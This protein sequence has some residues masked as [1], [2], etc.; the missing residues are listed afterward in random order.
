MCADVVSKPYANNDI[1]LTLFCRG[2]RTYGRFDKGEIAVGLPIA[3]FDSLA[4]GIVKTINPVDDPKTKDKIIERA[5][6]DL[7]LIGDINKKYRYGMGLIEYDEIIKFNN[8]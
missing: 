2:A 4:E 3:M 8:Q 6:D 7:D 1:N 5:K